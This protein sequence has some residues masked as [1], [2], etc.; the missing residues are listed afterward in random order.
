VAIQ[1]AGREVARVGRVDVA[2]GTAF[3]VHAVLEARDRDGQAVYYTSARRLEVGGREVPVASLRAWDRRE[4]VRVLWF[5]VEGRSPY[6]PLEPGATATGLSFSELFRADWPQTWAAPGALEPRH[7]DHLGRAREQRDR[8]FGTQR[9]HARI[10]VFDP[11][12]PTLPEARFKSWGAAEL[13]ERWQEF[14][15]VVATLPGV[16]APASAVFGLAQVDTPAE[17][18]AELLAE[19]ARLAER[20]LAFSLVTVLRSTLA[21]AGRD[22]MAD[23][24]WREV[25]LASSGLSWGADVR[26]GDL[27][28]SGLQ[29]A[30]LYSDAGIPGELDGADLALAFDR[31][32]TVLPLSVAVGGGLPVEHA[33][34]AAR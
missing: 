6:L 27:L 7:D 30:V 21:A 11:E 29:V 16:A 12:R 2:A 22:G 17:P 4:E 32:A 18:T 5:T 28:R 10:E 20:G 9:F 25:S 26:T 23:L 31:G 24:V 3:T 33:P 34:L 19:V 1:P 13:P 14:P 8:S 15:T